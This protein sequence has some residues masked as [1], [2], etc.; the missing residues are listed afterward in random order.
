MQAL[1]EIVAGLLCALAALA[2]AQFGVSLHGNP[3]AK[4]HPPEVHRTAKPAQ[5]AGYSSGTPAPTAHR[6]ARA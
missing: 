2:F 3:D 6:T 5:P 1:F 4:S